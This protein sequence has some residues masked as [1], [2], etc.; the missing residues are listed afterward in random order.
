MS[1]D[2]CQAAN[3]CVLAVHELLNAYTQVSILTE[4]RQ[5]FVSVIFVW[6]IA[7]PQSYLGLLGE[8]RPRRPEAMVNAGMGPLS[9]AADRVCAGTGMGAV[10]RVAETDDGH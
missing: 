9:G 3:G 8:R 2:D 1:Q 4:R 7:L 10:A 6:P 5:T